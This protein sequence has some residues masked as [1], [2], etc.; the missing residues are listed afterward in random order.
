MAEPHN[1]VSERERRLDEVL[2]AYLATLEPG[3]APDGR[4]V[5][6]RHPDLADELAAFFA[7]Q[8]RVDG[9]AAPLRSVAQAALATAA[10]TDDTPQ[11]SGDSAIAP[12]SL[13]GYDLLGEIGRGGMGIVYRARQRA[14]GRMVALKVLRAGDRASAE[15]V[16]RL[17]NEAETVAL[18]DHPNIVPVYDVGEHAGQLYLTMKLVEG[19][20]LAGQLDRFTADTKAAARLLA[21]V[22]RAVHHAHQRGVLHRDLKPSNILLERRT[23]SL[24]CPSGQDRQGSLS[25][26][27][28]P[29]VTD[30]GLAK[31]VAADSSLTQSG[32]LVG[33]PSYM[34]PEQ[35]DGQKGQVTTA[36]DVY[37]LGAVLYA[38]LTGRPPFRGETVLET[39]EQVKHA[40]PPSPGAVRRGV[41]RELETVCLKCLEKEPARRYGSAEELARD[42]ERWL[43]HEP[44]H[45][46]RMPWWRRLGKWARRR[47]AV[48]ALLVVL[49][50][51]TALGAAGGLWWHQRR[52]EALAAAGKTMAQARRLAEEGRWPAGLSAA[53]H[54]Q[55]TLAGFGRDQ[56]LGRQAAELARDLE[57][58]QR[59]EDAALARAADFEDATSTNA[60]ADA[61]RWYGLDPDQ[62]EPRAA[63]ERI[64][65]SLIAGRLVAALDDW[66][67]LSAERLHGR[68]ATLVAIARAADPDPQRNRLRD[69]LEGKDPAALEDALA[70]ASRQELPSST[71]VLFASQTFRTGT[72]GRERAVAVLRRAWQR[73]P[74]DFWLNFQLCGCLASLHPPQLDEAIRFGSAA[75]SLRPRSAGAHGNLGTVLYRKGRVGE[76]ITELRCA[77]SLQQDFAEAHNNLGSALAAQDQLDGAIKE[78]RTAVGLVSTEARYHYN[79][80]SGLQGRNGV[81]EALKELREATILDPE[82]AEAHCNLGRLLQRMGRFDEAV[83][84]LRLGHA[85]GIRR[86]HWPYRSLT[87]LREAYVSLGK[88]LEKQGN[89]PA[90]AAAFR[91]AIH[92]KGDDPRI[93][94]DL[95]VALHGQG[96]LADAVA[97]YRRAT[98]LKPD[99]AEAYSNLGAALWG[100]GQRSAAETAYRNAIA[101]DP[102][103]AVAYAN[104]GD[105]LRHLNKLPEA[106]A[107]CR[108]AIELN[109]NFAEAY[110]NLGLAL[111][112]QKKLPEAVAAYRQAIQCKRGYAEAHCN[113]GHALRDQ[114][115]F[116]PAL[117]ALKRGDELGS[118][119]PGWRYPSPQWVREAER[120]VT[121]ENRLPRFLKGE[122]QPADAA[123]RLALALFCHRY[124]HLHAAA[125]GW[126]KEGFAAQPALAGDLNQQHRYNAACAAALAGCGQG[127]DVPPPDEPQRRTWR[128]QALEWLRAD[129]AVYTNA[130]DGG[131]AQIRA[132][133]G[134]RLEQ[135]RQD[136]DLAGVREAALLEKLPKA[137]REGWRKL[138]KGVE[139]LLA[140]ARGRQK[141]GTKT[142][143]KGQAAT[144]QRTG[145]KPVGPG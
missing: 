138:W 102:R 53:R 119:T 107:V 31:R 19:A 141:D 63:G 43:N 35:A 58:A 5:I 132:A 69:V 34:A 70:T 128:K 7:D 121:L 9:W 83:K 113:L 50:A 100:L 78:W 130:V 64:R 82:Y 37:G 91:E 39:L 86:P 124:K 68:R 60:Y 109:P 96:K 15:D 13:G 66:A 104:L 133:V 117:A 10:T 137:E 79:L 55:A 38:L 21:T 40:E 18:L 20:S 2:G 26:D 72:T 76:A 62:V 71:A 118:R 30:F 1:D 108:K 11:L 42:L 116:A 48:A 25:S 142:A 134:Q 93:H 85:L 45:A 99:Y 92:L 123:E 8:E 52:A 73:H 23:G 139:Q 32:A 14:L 94:Y 3:Q 136:P 59:L 61:F 57:M 87:W 74:E 80:G 98:D 6:A 81:D 127:K 143:G 54:A 67:C 17:R 4:D 88:A 90:A 89:L 126:Y 101:A 46:R 41:D 103:Y 51:A 131:P 22:A 114:G 33:T 145:P 28:V 47:P 65:S 75:V 105:V 120:L 111:H 44:V 112:E 110:Y 144:G 56:G 12:E 115:K 129:L 27:L 125:A 95:G 97:A 24:A 49:V 84:E 16:Q 29:H 36:T 106:E 140:R 135:W 122:L 77:I